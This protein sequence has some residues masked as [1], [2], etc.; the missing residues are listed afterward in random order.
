MSA[1]N[2]QPAI[3]VFK[4]IAS[5]LVVV[6]HTQ[7]FLEINETLNF[8]IVQYIS[9]VAVPFFIISTG[10]FVGK[11]IFFENGSIV[12]IKD[13]RAAVLRSALK[14]LKMYII[15][16]L[17]YLLVSIPSWMDTGWFS[18]NAFIDWGIAFFTKGSYYHLW[19]LAEV[20][21]ALIILA[22]LLPF[23]KEKHIC[24][25]V[26]LL[27][28]V[29]V[30]SYGY[31][32]FLPSI[33]QEAFNMLD[34]IALPFESIVRVLPL[35]LIGIAIQKQNE[36]RLINNVSRFVL[37][38]ILLWIEICFVSKFG[39][40][41]FSYLIFTLPTAYFLFK[42][43]HYFDNKLKFENTVLLADVSTVV[44]CVH[45]AVIVFLKDVLSVNANLWVFVL[46]IL[47]SIAICVVVNYL[48]LPMQK[49][50]S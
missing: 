25:T 32:V 37:S 10:F 30:L 2:R 12:N 9:R 13:A 14:I 35:L 18:V 48:I 44:Y 28:F 20:C 31:R 3:D 42:V 11:K 15:W 23:L 43:V 38:M 1:K 26:C 40:E 17:V 41:S 4:L 47:I 21:Y 39:G 27:W 7:P 33:V 50:I 24:I 34:I 49:I 8:I 29:E 5:I 16:S 46:A 19:Y 36:I 6:I 22:V 45:P